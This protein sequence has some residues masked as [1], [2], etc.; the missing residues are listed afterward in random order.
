[1]TMDIVVVSKSSCETGKVTAPRSN[2]ISVFTQAFIPLLKTFHILTKV[3][4][5]K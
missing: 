5:K 2:F 3:K 1:M 4:I